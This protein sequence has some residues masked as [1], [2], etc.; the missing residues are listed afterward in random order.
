MWS[1]AGGH[2]GRPYR[3]A[4]V[5]ADGLG[6]NYAKGAREAALGRRPLCWGDA[7]L[8]VSRRRGDPCGRP[9]AA[10]KA[11]PTG[12]RKCKPMG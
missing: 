7:R 3:V 5:Q 8:N 10:I 2:K 1:P 12:L 6:A 4:E 9:R 11:A